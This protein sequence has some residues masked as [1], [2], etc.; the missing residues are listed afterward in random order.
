MT[1]LNR[2]F[3]LLRITIERQ[4]VI[5]IKKKYTNQ[6][7]VEA[8]SHRFSVEKRSRNNKTAVTNDIHLYDYYSVAL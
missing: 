3:V 6:R 2:T 7:R 1:R 8:C 5:T 4:Y